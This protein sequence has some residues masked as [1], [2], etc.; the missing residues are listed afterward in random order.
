LENREAKADNFT[1]SDPNL[2]GVDVTLKL[3]GG[4]YDNLKKLLSA[5]ETSILY[6]NVNGISYDTDGYELQL[7]TYYYQAP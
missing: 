6:F 3:K 4:S 2:R 7:R 1:A 5:M